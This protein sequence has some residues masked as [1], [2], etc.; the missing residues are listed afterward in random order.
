MPTTLYHAT[1]ADFDTFDFDM[2][3]S[4]ADSA[5]NSALGIWFATTSD[6]ISGFGQKVIE[7]EVELGH[8][9]TMTVTELMKL[10]KEFTKPGLG[11][12][13]THVDEMD[14]RLEPVTRWKALRAKLLACGY[15][16]VRIE[17]ANGTSAMHVIL[18]PAGIL[19]MKNMEPD[20]GPKSPGR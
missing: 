16:S 14:P 7:A 2:A 4:R 8:S 17:E 9:Y 19:S 1:T 13:E 20:A 11:H 12:A 3:G 10:S 5:E 6:W 15:T 18:S